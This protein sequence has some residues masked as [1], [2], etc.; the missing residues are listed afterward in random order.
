MERNLQLLSVGIAIRSF[1]AALYNPFLAL[2]LFSVLHVG[3]FEIGVIFVGVGAVQLPFGLVGGLWTDRVGRRKLII[4]G[5]STEALLTASLAYAFDIHSLAL[6]IA[7]AAVGGAILAATA[8][9]YS[10][11]IADWASGSTR[12]RAFTW[13]RI[14]YN[15]GFAA[16]VSLGGI[17]VEFIGFTGAVL[18][19]SIIIAGATAFVLAMIRPSPFDLALRERVKPTRATADSEGGGRSLR[20]SF[21]ILSRDRVALL[22]ATGFALLWVTAGQ[23][24]VTFSLFSHNKFGISYSLLGL[25]LA[26]NGLVVV[27]GQSITTESLLGRRHTSIAIA[28][29]L[30][31]A[32][33]YL[34]LGISALWLL[35]P[36]GV[37]LVVVFVL[38]IGENVGTIPVTTLPSNLAPKGEVGAYN[39]AFNTFLSAASLAAI[40]FGGAILSA[41]PN[42]LWEWVLLILPTIPGVLLLR[43]AARRI[44]REIDRA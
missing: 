9:A 23:W 15:G 2:F 27:F 36:S 13:F 8:A 3:Y 41:V 10:A 25:G 32:A 39:G 21:S 38:T 12:T 24:N 17:L 34:L 7:V 37:F 40:F 31:Y 26:L 35:F 4:L 33:A 28:G 11:Y 43:L 22:V 42:P 30:L 18:A 29:G 1:G 19:A 44:P 16:G 14:S 20:E 5:L 6:A